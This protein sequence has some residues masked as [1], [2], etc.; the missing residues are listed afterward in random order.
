M[1]GSAASVGGYVATT[2][3]LQSYVP[4]SIQDDYTTGKSYYDQFSKATQ[5]ITIGPHGTVAI[6]DSAK[7]AI[8]DSIT[9]T[10]A[11]AVPV[12]GVAFAALMALAPSAGAG[13]GV[14]STDP[15]INALPSTL[16]GWPHFWGWANSYGAYPQGA[17]GSFEAY[18]NPVL[19][20]N[21]LLGANCFG[22]RQ[23]PSQV[24]LAGLIASWNAVHSASSK[25][26]VSRSFQHIKSFGTNANF[27]PIAD[28]LLN[29][30][31]AKNTH[32]PPD[33]TFQQ[34]TDPNAYSGPDQAT[35]SFVI[36]NGGLILNPLTLHNPGG[37]DSATGPGSS[38]P[39]AGKRIAVASL[40]IVGVGA[41]GVGVW[42]LATHQSYLGAL[43]GIWGSSGGKVVKHV[44]PLPL[45]AGESSKTKVQT[46]LFPWPRYSESRAKAWAR[47]HGFT[48]H[49]TDVTDNNV[50]LR[51]RPPSAFKSGTF[52]TIT[53][54]KSGVKAVVGHLR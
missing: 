50:R 44:N 39:S 35:S 54:G 19:E 47:A 10:V 38:T 27:D 13:P 24:L 37:L 5:G 11:A 41:A 33:P 52:R 18:A 23:I 7:Q 21:W 29:D 9:A 51:Q 20:Y 17:A 31:V 43:K 28:A 8:A 34:A 36:N 12:L 15:P 14:C 40:I 16:A 3:N 26:T 2:F 6:S 22:D 42:A 48:A 4:Q 25:R 53:L 46:L 30:V 49:K 45:A 1:V 32:L